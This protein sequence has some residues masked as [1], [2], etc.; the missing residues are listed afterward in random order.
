MLGRVCREVDN[1]SARPVDQACT[2]SNNGVMRLAR[3]A[4]VVLEPSSEAPL[5]WA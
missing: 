5:I 2:L 3:G 4:V 1:R